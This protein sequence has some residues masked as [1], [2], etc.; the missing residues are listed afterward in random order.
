MKRLLKTLLLFLIIAAFNVNAQYVRNVSK[1]GTVAAPFLTI[2]QGARAT[3]MGS[4]F[5]AIADDPASIVW[6]AAGIARLQNNGVV[7]DHTSWIAGL[8]Y[9]FVAASYNLGNF[10]TVGASLIM[11]DYGEMAVTTVE[12]PN[13]TGEK[14]KVS[15][16]AFSFAWAIN[17][18][19]DFSIGFN[20]KVVH[21]S[22]WNMSAT[23][24]AVDMG[25]L[26]NTPFKG[27]TLG[28]SI[29]NFGTKMKLDGS[30]ATILYDPDPNTTGNNG[31]IPGQLF[32]DE[33]S[34]PLGFKLGVAYTADLGDMHKIVLDFDA[35]HP[36]NDY[37]YVNIGGEYSFK[38]MIFIRSG[39]KSL[40]LQDSEESFALGAGFNQ[41]ISG[42]LSIR[43]DYSYASFGRLKDTQ[44]FSVGLTF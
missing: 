20:P 2:G 3:G 5:V 13:G 17:L 9:N 23:A 1:R 22:I 35:A 39:Y 26:Y 32:A 12:N 16:I 24:I 21:Q 44:K 14:F 29:T 31:R 6:N 4:A 25:V 43:F 30:T 38:N 11:S 33:W 41:R 15:D 36:N 37:E 19:E 18:T 7:F 8:K 42:D 34:L 27:F 10:G 40:F 28:M